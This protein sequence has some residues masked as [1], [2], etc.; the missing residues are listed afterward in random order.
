MEAAQKLNLDEYNF[1]LRGGI[2]CWDAPF[3]MQIIHFGLYRFWI[4]KLRW[5]IL[6]V[7]WTMYTGT[8]SL[9]LTSRDLPTYFD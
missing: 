8:I 4:V 5:T 6:V 2:V 9:N 3:I 1:F 7:G